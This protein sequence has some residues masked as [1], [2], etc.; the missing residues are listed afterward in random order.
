LARLLLVFARFRGVSGDIEQASAL[1]L[2]AA[3]LAE[4]IGLSGLRLAA[5]V[6]LSSW[7]TQFGDLRRSLDIVEQALRDVPT[8]PRV[9]SEHLGYSPY[10][11]LVMNSVRLLAYMGRT[12]EAD[13]AL[14]RALALA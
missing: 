11:W 8:N 10:I 2:D 1:S 13:E 5:T 3:K 12:A 9:G 4:Q 6:N 7:A 14:D